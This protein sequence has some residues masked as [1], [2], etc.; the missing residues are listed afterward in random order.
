MS[1]ENDKLR[2][3]I[4][5]SVGKKMQ[6]PKDFDQLRDHIY[7]RLRILISPTTLK[8]VW[9]Y[10]PNSGEPSQN[11]L[12]IL[13]QFIGYQDL[14]SFRLHST[15]PDVESSNPVMSRHINV[16]SDLTKDDTLT[17]FWLPDPQRRNVSASP[18][19]SPR[20]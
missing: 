7:S 15:S 1:R 9:G 10:L 8:R 5:K 17:L 14:D 12:D 6:T 16:E 2:E 3:A 4:E 20:P 19:N 18:Q 11:T 13:A